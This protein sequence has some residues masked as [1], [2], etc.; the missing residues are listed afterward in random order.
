MKAPRVALALV[1]LVAITCVIHAQPAN[2]DALSRAAAKLKNSQPLDFDKLGVEELKNPNPLAGTAWYHHR[3]RLGQFGMYAFEIFVFY[4][5]GTYAYFENLF[6]A[7]AFIEAKYGQ[8]SYFLNDR[9]LNASLKTAGTYTVDEAGRVRLN[10]TMVNRF[11]KQR[12]GYKR[13][14]YVSGWRRPMD[15]YLVGEVLRIDRTK[16]TEYDLRKTKF[17]ANHFGKTLKEAH[18]AQYLEAP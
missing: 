6:T 9:D 7:T 15:R 5:D 17:Y 3:Y 14:D 8:A 11:E 13:E 18:G 12:S 16:P 10:L 1:H 4:E 2:G